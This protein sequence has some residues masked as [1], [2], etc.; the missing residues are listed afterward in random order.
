MIMLEPLPSRNVA[1]FMLPLADVMTVLFSLFLLLPHLEH[2]AEL[3]AGA[4]PRSG[5]YWDAEQQQIIREELDRLRQFAR[6]EARQRVLLIVLNI[7]NDTGNLYFYE[8]GNYVRVDS[9]AAVDRM[10][11]RHLALAAATARELHYK[12]VEPRPVDPDQKRRPKFG[13][14]RNYEEWFRKWKSRQVHYEIVG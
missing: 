13:D 8:D 12:L 3:S 5:E 1:R 14:L 11:E 7:D 2:A 9:A 10:V 4:A 6:L